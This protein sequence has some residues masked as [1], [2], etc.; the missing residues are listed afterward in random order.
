MEKFCHSFYNFQRLCVKSRVNKTKIFTNKSK[1]EIN[2]DVVL[3]VGVILWTKEIS[4]WESGGNP[5]I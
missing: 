5:A 2:I 1:E 3:S 4:Y